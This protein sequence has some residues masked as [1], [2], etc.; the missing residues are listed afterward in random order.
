MDKALEALKKN[1]LDDAEK[2]LDEAA[3]LAPNHPDILY[4]QGVVFLQR[5][6]PEKAR[7]FLE[8]AAQIDPKNARVL[9]ALGMASSTKA[10]LTLPLR[11]SNTP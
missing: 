6:Q 9:S 4:L 7:G 10:A 1:K 2:F 3:K 11:R 8:K 5:N